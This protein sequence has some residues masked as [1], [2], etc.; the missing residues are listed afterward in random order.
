MDMS[1]GLINKRREIMDVV[2]YI[3]EAK[4]ICKS[5]SLCN[6]VSGKC[7]LLEENG[8][9]AATVNICAADIIEKTEKAVQIVE[10]WAKEH[11]IKTRQ[12]EFLRMFPNAQIHDDVIWMC[13]KCI[14][15][16]YK[17]EE[18]CNEIYCCDCKRKF[19]LTEVTDN[20]NVC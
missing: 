3:K 4:R 11:P 16:D 5:R 12:S 14:G 6:S 17:P 9:C 1:L 18:N 2:E 10:Q 15:C 8:H 20:G 13:P 19:W 7:P